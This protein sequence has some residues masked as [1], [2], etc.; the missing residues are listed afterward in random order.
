MHPILPQLT[1]TLLFKG[2]TLILN[3]SYLF[4]VMEANLPRKYNNIVIK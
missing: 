2:T 3:Q 4:T 1:Q